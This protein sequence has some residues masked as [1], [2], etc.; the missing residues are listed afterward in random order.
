MSNQ[1]FIVCSSSDMVSWIANLFWQSI[2]KA[3]WCSSSRSFNVSNPD[4]LSTLLLDTFILTLVCYRQV[5]DHCW[6]FFPAS[7]VFFFSISSYARYLVSVTAIWRS[8]VVFREVL[9][10]E[11]I[12][13]ITK[14]LAAQ[15]YTPFSLV[16]LYT[17][18]SLF[19]TT[20][21]FITPTTLVSV[22][23]ISPVTFSSSL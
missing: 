4:T 8:P 10:L 17:V 1:S 9:L 20:F 15:N 12:P 16:S 2:A 7:L 18:P 22:F 6:H 5:G 23:G 3:S 14:L 19:P 11:K 21:L 13:L